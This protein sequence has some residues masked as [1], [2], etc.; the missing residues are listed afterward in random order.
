[1]T[2]L[3]DLDDNNSLINSEPEVKSEPLL[4]RARNLFS[5]L[6]KKEKG[7][8]LSWEALSNAIPKEMRQTMSDNRISVVMNILSIALASNLVYQINDLSAFIEQGLYFSIAYQWVIGIA[9]LS[10]AFAY[11]YF[12]NKKAVYPFL[13]LMTYRQSF[14][15]LDFELRRH[16]FE[17]QQLIQFVLMQVFT[18]MVFVSLLSFIF[19]NL[20]I[21][22]AGNLV[23]YL[24][25]TL[26]FLV[27][28]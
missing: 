20:K 18:V 27:I 23:A 10:L 16:R 17:E 12:D 4:S 8:S 24:I 15:L 2:A 11:Y 22:V 1:M 9:C 3:K 13:L 21:V 26:G 6:R 19:T 7:D 14:A 5:C 28:S 25:T